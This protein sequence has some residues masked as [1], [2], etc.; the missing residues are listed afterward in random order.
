MKGPGRGI[1]GGGQEGCG[2]GLGVAG[3]QRWGC[4][5]SLLCDDDALKLDRGDGCTAL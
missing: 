4:S 5:V 1:A 3:E 2:R